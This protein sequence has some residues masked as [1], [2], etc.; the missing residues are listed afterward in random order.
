MVCA[1]C[2]PVPSLV[3]VCPGSVGEPRWPFLCCL[4]KR[5]GPPP[6]HRDTAVPG[7]SKLENTLGAVK[8]WP[9]KDS[10]AG[11]DLAASLLSCAGLSRLAVARHG[12]CG[13]RLNAGVCISRNQTP[14]LN[15]WA[16]T[17]TLLA[18]PLQHLLARVCFLL[19]SC[20]GI[21]EA[22]AFRVLESC[23]HCFVQA[24]IAMGD[25]S[26]DKHMSESACDIKMPL[27][28]GMSRDAGRNGPCK[29]CA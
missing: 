13:V 15:R 18:R 6:L 28:P 14:D 21:Q 11:C 22:S 26:R 1:L 4:Q 25:T 16:S 7:A 8:P 19:E 5:G 20:P 27:R 3:R 9:R 12:A 2:V 24:H 17:C 10:A 29:R 23:C